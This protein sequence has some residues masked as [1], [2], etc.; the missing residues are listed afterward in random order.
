MGTVSDVILQEILRL[1]CKN[2]TSTEGV[3]RRAGNARIMKETKEQ[4][5]AGVEVDFSDKPV[6]L[7]AA[8]LKVRERQDAWASLNH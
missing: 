3:F 6:L 1:L 8:L 2:G 4:L 5:N 7:L